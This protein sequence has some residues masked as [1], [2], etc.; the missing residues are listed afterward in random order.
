MRGFGGRV[1]HFERVKQ[2]SRVLGSAASTKVE[3]M[4]L[5]RISAI[6]A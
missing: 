1:F 2:D 6:K 4:K 3:A 5:K